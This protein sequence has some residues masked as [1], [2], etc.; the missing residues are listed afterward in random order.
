M[1]ALE[2][3]IL[4]NKDRSEI[5][6]DNKSKFQTLNQEEVDNGEEVQNQNQEKTHSECESQEQNRKENNPG[7][8]ILDEVK[9]E[10]LFGDI[11]I[12]NFYSDYRNE[13]NNGIT[14]GD[15]ATMGDI[16]FR[17]YNT[18][19]IQHNDAGSLAKDSVK[20]GQWISENYSKPSLALLITIAVFDEMPYN[21]IVEEKE[22]LYGYLIGEEKP[23]YEAKAIERRL[24]EIGAE[25]CDGEISDYAGKRHERFIRY[26]DSED[27]NKIIQYIWLQFPNLKMPILKWFLKHIKTGRSIYAKKITSV[28]SVL[29]SIDYDYF[30]NRIIPRLYQEK[31][32]SVDITL[33]QILNQLVES[34]RESIISMLTHWSMQER[35]HPLLVTL[36]VTREMNSGQK[37]LRQAMNTYLH[38]IYYE[39]HK[40]VNEFLTYIIDFFAVGVRKAVFYRLLIEELYDLFFQEGWLK[41]RY[42]N[43]DLFLGLFWIDVFLSCGGDEKKEEPVLIKMC[44]V[45][46]GAK[47]KLCQIWNKMWK[48]HSYRVEFYQAL[49]EYYRLLKNEIIGE[50]ILLFLDMILGEDVSREKKYDIYIKIKKQSEK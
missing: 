44:V 33:S 5:E 39:N 15:N 50:R 41:N 47:N 1:Q 35:V 37:I 17:T 9:K 4:E 25:V 46:N 49:G 11:K 21:R 3:F 27:A 10:K 7:L 13:I 29:A 48:T 18:K 22:D 16:N 8:N 38:V 30:V 6:I 32:I 45:E 24:L 12:Y 42:K 14:I 26:Q 34:H 36:L 20:L 43:L 28:L 23:V 40:K 2:R 19:D 31:N